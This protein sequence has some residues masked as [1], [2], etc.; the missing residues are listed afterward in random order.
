[1]TK[2]KASKKSPKRGDLYY[3]NESLL[4]QPVGQETWP[5]RVGLVVSN[6]VFNKT[7]NCIQIVYVS[8]SPHKL[9][10]LTPTHIPIL[11]DGKQ[12]I[13]ICEQVYTVDISRLSHQVDAIDKETMNLID[14]AVL[15]GLGINTGK[16]PQ[17]LFRKWE[18]YINTY[19]SLKEDIKQATTF[20][21]SQCN[22]YK[23]LIDER[24]AYKNLAESLQEKLTLIHNMTTPSD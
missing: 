21:E 7:S 14:E 6:D 10:N 13:A 16:N 22:I 8:T 1:M 23:N 5:N 18:H 17:G 12:A 20:P 9:E 2:S 4:W 19:P 15:F 24:N 11:S 3:I